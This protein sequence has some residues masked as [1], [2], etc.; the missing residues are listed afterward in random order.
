ML[1]LRT[2]TSSGTFHM[3][4]A[5]QGDSKGPVDRHAPPPFYVDVHASVAWSARPARPV[6]LASWR[7]PLQPGAPAGA[8]PASSPVWLES[9]LTA[10]RSAADDRRRVAPRALGLI[11]CRRGGGVPRDLRES[12]DFVTVPPAPAAV[13]VRH[14]VPRAGLRYDVVGEPAAV[15]VPRV[16]ERFRVG[17]SE[18]SLATWW[19]RWG[20][21]AG[22]LRDKRFQSDHW[23]D[24]R[25]DD[26]E[27]GDWMESEGDNG[28]GLVMQVENMAEVEFVP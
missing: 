11:A 2:T 3:D 10:F 12:W 24:G 5:P 16:G 9:A 14:V 18:A 23:W 20:D 22:D 28:F 25:E 4:D 13:T 27:G 15:M 17:P 26:R 7:T 1:S 8:A 6:T 19:W 21:L